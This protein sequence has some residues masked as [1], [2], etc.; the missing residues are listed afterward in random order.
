MFLNEK[1]PIALTAPVDCPFSRLRRIVESAAEG[2]LLGHV[3][4][5]TTEVAWD[6]PLNF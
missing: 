3:A 1:A 4:E 6:G 2:C 5:G